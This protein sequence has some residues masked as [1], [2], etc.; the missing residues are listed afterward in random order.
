MLQKRKD[1]DLAIVKKRFKIYQ[2]RSA[3]IENIVQAAGWHFKTIS[4]EEQDDKLSVEHLFEE[5]EK[6]QSL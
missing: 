5:Y 1:D 4:P 3:M 2:D 6:Q